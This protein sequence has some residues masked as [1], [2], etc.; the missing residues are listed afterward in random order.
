MQKKYTLLKYVNRKHSLFTRS[1]LGVTFYLFILLITRSMTMA[2][3]SFEDFLSDDFKL[4]LRRIL[5]ILYIFLGVK[6]IKDETFNFCENA[7]KKQL[8]FLSKKLKKDLKR[9]DS[10]DLKGQYLYVLAGLIEIDANKKRKLINEMILG[11]CYSARYVDESFGT[12][13]LSNL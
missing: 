4:G 8:D 6:F 5:K 3:L 2:Q 9:K 1:I 10:L 11:G 7:T 13:N 12:H